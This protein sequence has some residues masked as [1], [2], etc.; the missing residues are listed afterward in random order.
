MTAA[1]ARRASR[2]ARGLKQARG[3]S[4]RGQVAVAPRVRRVD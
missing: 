2:E 1:T 3:V 4:L